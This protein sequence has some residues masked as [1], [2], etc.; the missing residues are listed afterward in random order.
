[1]VLWLVVR[2]WICAQTLRAIESATG[3]RAEAKAVNVEFFAGRVSLQGIVLISRTPATLWEQATVAN[4]SGHILW[5]EWNS[6]IIPMEVTLEDCSVSL[7]QGER[8]R[9]LK[10]QIH[11]QQP[12]TTAIPTAPDQS[13]TAK[14][15]IALTA[16]TARNVT[17]IDGSNRPALASGLAF[18]ARRG[19]AGWH[20]EL[21]AESL[22]PEPL[23]L[24][25]IQI[26]FSTE[27]QGTR[28]AEFRC[29]LKE[30]AISGN[31]WRSDD[32]MTSL[33][34]QVDSLQL[35]SVAPAWC[36]AVYGAVSGTFSYKGDPIRWQGGTVMGSFALKD[37]ALKF[38]AAAQMLS[39]VNGTNPGGVIQLDSATGM[40]SLT[41]E[42]WTL[43]KLAIKKINLFAMEGN[44]S[45][46]QGAKLKA[47]LKLG[48]AKQFA[49]SVGQPATGDGLDEKF[50]WTSLSLETTPEQ[51]FQEMLA[52][53]LTPA[54][55]QSAQFTP[56]KPVLQEKAKTAV[57][58]V[59]NLLTR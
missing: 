28:V 14:P 53:L 44:L 36:N 30:G 13:T 33:D 31:G 54:T 27:T 3:A 56:Q 41:Q 21:T 35:A 17:I 20:G 25:H 38:G 16:L 9:L 48:I 45:C 43:S 11:L 2:S 42:H 22:G 55:T 39:L 10:E 29:N 26:G 32:G 23:P 7:R 15:K 12:A 47:D 5:T 58:A 57:D 49:L 8:L 34:L 46:S 40:L 6:G 18:T 52:A 37:G 51:L 19:I 4:A 24:T 50:K 59:I 1:M